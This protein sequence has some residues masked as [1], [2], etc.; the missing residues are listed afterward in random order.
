MMTYKV[1][2]TVS[3]T[4]G[5]TFEEVRIISN[6][7]QLLSEADAKALYSRLAPWMWRL[8][9]IVVSHAADASARERTPRELLDALAAKAVKP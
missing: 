6:R 3:K 4:D 7:L 9:D 1:E 5:D 2:L 8:P